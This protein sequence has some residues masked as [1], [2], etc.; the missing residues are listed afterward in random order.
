MFFR[1][2]R[3]ARVIGRDAI[4]LW[5]ACRNPMTPMSVKLGI[6]LMALYV[7]SPIDL[8]SDILPVL[9]WID[10]V[11][12]LA[13]GIPAVLKLIPRPALHEAQSATERLLSKWTFWQRRS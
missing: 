3:L 11:T 13:F 1:L 9:G 7:I 2:S 6:V 4:V 12:L 8:V 10:D 5:Y